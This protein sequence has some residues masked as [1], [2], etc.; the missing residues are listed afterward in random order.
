MP[1]KNTINALYDIELSRRC[2]YRLAII[3]M[4][5]FFTS[6]A[7]AVII[8]P[9]KVDLS[10]DH[11]VVTITVTNDAGL[12]LIL[13]NQVL[14][15]TQVNGEDYLEESNDLLVAPAIVEI[16]PGDNQIF[17]VTQRDS[18]VAVME[19]AYRLILDDISTLENQ[20]QVNGVNFVISHRL[21]VFVA[22]TGKVGSKPQFVNCV[23]VTKHSCVRLENI[24]DQYVQ[25][26]TLRVNGNNWHQDLESGG[27]ILA[28]AWKQWIFAPPPASAGQ[29]TLTVETT[30]GRLSFELPHAGEESSGLVS[31]QLY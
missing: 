8:S 13:Q 10:P 4:G 22:G 20:P 25:I 21:P 6:T 26:R 3:A 19:R 2:L 11:P 23:N 5:S 16:K 30:E 29:L 12:P 31:Q 9:V 17:R 1:F 14:A 7:L 18:T 15:W 24:G 28:G 27:R